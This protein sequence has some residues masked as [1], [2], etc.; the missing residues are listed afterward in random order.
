[1]TAARSVGVAVLLAV[2]AAGTLTYW[3]AFF[4]GGRALHA[5]ERDVYFAFEHAF[6]AADL[7]MAG[8]A[9]IAAVALWQGRAAAVLFGIAAGSALV[10]LGLLDVL[11]DVEQRLYARA[12]AAMAV[13]AVIN[14]YCL[15]VGPFLMRWFWRRRRTLDPP[16]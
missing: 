15:T 14:V 2:T 1:M 11:F 9:A 13:E 12:S 10:F 8:V 5:D 4:A 16:R 6:P 7:W 3:I